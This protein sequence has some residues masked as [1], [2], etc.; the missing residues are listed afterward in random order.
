MGRHKKKYFSHESAIIEHGATI[1]ENTRIWHFSHIREGATVGSNCTISKDCFIDKNVSI[2]NNVKIQNGVSIYKGVTVEDDVFIGPNVTFTNDP[3]PRA[4]SKNW[5]IHPTRIKK[6]ASIGANATLVCGINIGYYA[7]VAAGSVVVR[8]VP[9]N[10]MVAGN[11]AKIKG[12]VCECGMKLKRLSIKSNEML[13]KC[14]SCS[15]EILLPLFV[16]S[17]ALKRT[18]I[19]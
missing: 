6:G 10:C 13:F 11:P 4:F 9:D 7:M 17:L 1:G 19:K 18:S 15:K 12:F 5:G 2:G 3:Y 8:N 14:T 16:A